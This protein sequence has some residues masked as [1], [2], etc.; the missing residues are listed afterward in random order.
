M[1]W[2]A[3]RVATPGAVHHCIADACCALPTSVVLLSQHPAEVGLIVSRYSACSLMYIT[4]RIAL[5]VH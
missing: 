3:R 5:R 1:S 2:I 4:S